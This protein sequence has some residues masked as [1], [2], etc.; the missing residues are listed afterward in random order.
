VETRTV[1]VGLVA[2]DYAQV[3]SG[4]AVGEAVVTGSSADRT[5]TTT[6]TTSGRGGFGGLDG[7][8]AG[9]PPPGFGGE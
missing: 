6:T 8:P 9:G 1:E 3:T 7:M 4:I 5:T 2:S